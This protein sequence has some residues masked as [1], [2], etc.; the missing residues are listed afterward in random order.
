MI[1]LANLHLH[2]P[3][4]VFQHG[5]N[6]LLTQMIKS[7]VRSD[8]K[9]SVYHDPISGRRCGAGCFIAE[10][11]Y[12]P[13]FEFKSWPQLVIDG[14]VPATHYYLINFFQMV[15]DDCDVENWEQILNA[16]KIFDDLAA[17]KRYKREIGGESIEC[18][19]G[20]LLVTSF[21]R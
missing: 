6:H 12:D 5:K 14:K 2:A 10:G 19:G 1:T 3:E 13:S 7:V 17:A 16:S 21:P 15:H 8:I 20:K 11:E 4:E 9:E 18:E